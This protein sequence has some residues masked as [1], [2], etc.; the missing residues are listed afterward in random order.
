M[1]IANLNKFLRKKCPHIF[2]EINISEYSY[3]KVAI[4]ISLY[5]CKFK[6]SYGDR[7][8]S[9]FISLVACLRKNDVHCVFIYDSGCVPEKE[10]ERKERA[11]Q[12]CKLE[13]RV[14]KLEEA[15][16]KF[17]LTSEIDPI[18]IELYKKRISKIET[19]R[20]I[21]KSTETIDIK[22]VEAAVSK[23]R[24][25]ILNISSE[26]FILTKELFDILDVPYFNAPLEAETMC[27]DL[28]KRG[29]VDAVLSEDTDV[30]AYASPIFLSKIN[31]TTGHCIKIEYPE[32]LS[33]MEMKSEEFLDFCIMCGTDYNKNIFKVGPEKSYKYIK[34]SSTI[35]KIA[36]D[37]PSL[38][39]TILNHNR[40]RYLFRQYEQSD[41]K[42]PYCGQPNFQLLTIFLVKHNI[43]TN[44][45][46]LKS[47][48][49]HTTNIVFEDDI[50]SENDS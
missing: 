32:L 1:G 30:L 15:L 34:K 36:E 13:T 47:S 25:H 39:I 7:W 29:L 45:E 17:Y 40:G 26:D 37:N 27:S 43:Q 42:I 44:I 33:G 38:D 28:C 14:Y 12:R 41:I 6:S 22:F 35:E 49:V 9:A 19:K 2:K 18:L 16:E 21:K 46:L 24:T 8:M 48:F 10:A 31:T 23:M 4:D 5:L 11:V 50:E 20:L 3:K